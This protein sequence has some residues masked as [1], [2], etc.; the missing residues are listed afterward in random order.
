MRGIAFGRTR[1]WLL[2][3]TLFAWVLL[4]ALLRLAL[5]QDATHRPDEEVIL[6]TTTSTADTGLLDALA[7]CYWKR[8]DLP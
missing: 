1:T 4:L 8:P 7:P 3:V 6:A 5:G 2:V